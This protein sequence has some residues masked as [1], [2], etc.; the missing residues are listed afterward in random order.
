MDGKDSGSSLAH[1]MHVNRN[2]AMVDHG[3]ISPGKQ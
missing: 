2:F 1:E 3:M